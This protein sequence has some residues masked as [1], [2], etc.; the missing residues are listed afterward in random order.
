MHQTEDELL[1]AVF[2]TVDGGLIVLEGG[3]HV[4]AWNAWFASA[5]GISAHD[6]VGKRLDELFPGAVS[7]G[8]TSAITDALETG[9]SRLL[10]HTLHP[11]L[12]PLRTRSAGRLIHN[13]SV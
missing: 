7:S 3:M 13:I 6:A 5:S 1:S 4:V 10:T 8:L 11:L 9:S 12:L 2:D